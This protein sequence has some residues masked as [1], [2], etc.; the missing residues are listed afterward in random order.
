M[1][2]REREIAHSITGLV[3]AQQSAH[4]R[5]GD[6]FSICIRLSLRILRRTVYSKCVYMFLIYNF[7][8][9]VH[10]VGELLALHTECR[11]VLLQTKQSFPSRAHKHACSRS[12]PFLLQ[13]WRGV[14]VL[15]RQLFN[16]TSHVTKTRPVLLGLWVEM[17]RCALASPMTSLGRFVYDAC[18]APVAD[19]QVVTC[20]R[21]NVS[22]R[23][24]LAR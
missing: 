19:Q 23:S 5:S 24:F 6:H 14:Q 13:S 10:V 18:A 16:V 22:P 1:C 21:R 15:E 11:Q 20:G 8:R 4:F 7:G 12:I 2:L 9:N 3:P 17:Q